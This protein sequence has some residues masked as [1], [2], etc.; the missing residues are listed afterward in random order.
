MVNMVSEKASQF[1]SELVERITEITKEN[2]FLFFSFQ[3][4]FLDILL[5]EIPELNTRKVETIE[6][7]FAEKMSDFR[8]FIVSKLKEV[9]SDQET[10][11]EFLGVIIEASGIK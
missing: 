10:L 7:K 3:A 8:E 5:K 11:A 9:R 4:V 2:K 6:F 1:A